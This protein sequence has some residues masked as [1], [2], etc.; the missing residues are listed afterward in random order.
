[1]SRRDRAAGP[2]AGAQGSALEG[3]PLLPAVNLLPPSVGEAA[4]SRALQIRL[5]IGLVVLVALLGVGYF[6]LAFWKGQAE[7]RVE[8]AEQEAARLASEKTKFA[9]LI[10]VERQIKDAQD[11]KVAA[12]AY[13]LK[14]P[15]LFKAMVDTRPEGSVVNSISGVGMSA[16]QPV[17]QSSNVLARPSVGRMTVVLVVPTL[18]AAAQWVNTLNATPGLESA[19]YQNLT[20]ETADAAG[21]AGYRI[22]CSA[23]INLIGLTG[24]SLPPEFEEW[25]VKAIAA[26]KGEEPEEAPETTEE[27][28][29]GEQ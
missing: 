18:Q 27:P 5:V 7:A 14:W 6:G 17:F 23:E 9:E 21:V 11:A 10:D 28:E 16:N 13:E 25:R 2:A 8:A 12:T 24:K 4:A 29:E 19:G 3:R 20:R 22:S 1:M 15:E 26:Q